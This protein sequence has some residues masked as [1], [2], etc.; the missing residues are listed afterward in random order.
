MHGLQVPFTLMSCC[1]AFSQHQ[2]N[3]N[4]S[5]HQQLKAAA[6]SSICK[7]EASSMVTRV[8]S[9]RW[10]L[11]L[12]GCSWVLVPGLLCI[13]QDYPLWPLSQQ[14][15]KRWEL[16]NYNAQQHASSSCACLAQVWVQFIY[17][18]GEK[19]CFLIF[20]TAFD[21]NYLLC[22]YTQPELHVLLWS[23]FTLNA[24]AA[25]AQHVVSRGGVSACCY[26]FLFELRCVTVLL[27]LADL[28]AT[29]FLMS[30][31]LSCATTASQ[32]LTMCSSHI[33]FYCCRST[34]TALLLP[35]I[36][37]R[38]PA[39]LQTKFARWDQVS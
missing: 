9:M 20:E 10:S 15:L 26:T 7:H 2:L 27:G 12:Q 33:L 17:S 30:S 21:Q 32:V 36:D 5:V 8:H 16:V 35:G 22:H 1:C 6:C 29:H 18:A 13:C 11:L 38:G 39:C 4:G 19:Q 28:L 23:V 24:T 14:L 25:T 31:W 37:Y 3:I 34:G